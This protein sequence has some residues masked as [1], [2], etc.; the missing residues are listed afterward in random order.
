MELIN[1]F[2]APIHQFDIIDSTNRFAKELCKDNPHNGTIVISNEQSQGRGR[3]G[4]TWES[5]RDKGLYYSIIF[6]IP[7]KTLKCELLTLYI[8]LGITELLSDYSIECKIKWPNDILINDKKVCGILSE[9][10]S[11]DH[12]VFIVVG[13]GVNLYHTLE[14][15]KGDLSN[16]ATSISLNT[17]STLIK[18]FF[19]NSLTSY[20]FDYY[21]Y[22][23]KND[24]ENFINTYK[25][26]SSLLNKEI[27]V[28]LNG[29]VISGYVHGFDNIGRLLLDTG[30]KITPINSGEV[31]LRDTYKK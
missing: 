7:D 17:E 13:I 16:K 15:F 29:D 19:I 2:N 9:L 6:K 1:A 20:L 4:N 31:T 23:L 25:N 22:F 30:D 10:V 14:D 11:N 21:N 27:S 24:F 8:S 3:L 18:N 28:Y 5:H 12:G 26:H